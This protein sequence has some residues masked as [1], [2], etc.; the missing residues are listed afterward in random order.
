MGPF[1]SVKPQNVIVTGCSSG[2]GAATAVVLRS[3]GWN[4]VPT[5]RRDQDLERLQREG[6]TPLRLDVADSSSVQQAAEEVLHCF[7]GAPGALVNNAGF[8]QLGAIE[9]LSRDTMK[10]QFEVNVF[11]M[12][13]FT[14]C[15]IPVFRQQGHGRIVNISSVFGRVCMPFNALY[16]AS[17]F[18]ME[19]LSDGLRVELD[20]T[21]IGVSLI[22]PGPIQSAFR[23]NALAQTASIRIDGSP[24]EDMYRES[25]SRRQSEPQKKR[26]FTL[27]PEAVAGKIVHALESARPR[28]RYCVTVHAYGGA[29]LRRF[30]PEGLLDWIMIRSLE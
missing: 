29:F 20:G 13:E 9:D 16:S 22:E 21:G 6:F 14:N 30:A 3:R 8:G 1:P 12:Q 25:I 24:F 26:R 15:L 5:A 7:D 28:R 17:K 27:P 19:A 2:I 4:V 18:A 11:G 10:R 23:E